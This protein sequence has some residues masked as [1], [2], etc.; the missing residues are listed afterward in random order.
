MTD[1][2]KHPEAS[3]FIIDHLVL[4]RL[5][6]FHAMWCTADLAHRRFLDRAVRDLLEQKIISRN[7]DGRYAL[8]ASSQKALAA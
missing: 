7:R 6:S 1:P 2:V 3:A 8:T 4:R 5:S